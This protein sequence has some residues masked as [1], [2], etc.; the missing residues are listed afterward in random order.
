[1]Q[2]FTLGDVVVTTFSKG[3]RHTE[4][5]VSIEKKIDDTVMEET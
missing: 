1:M 2:V 5:Q 4:A 3:G